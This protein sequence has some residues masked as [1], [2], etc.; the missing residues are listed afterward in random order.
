MNE[1]VTKRVM[2]NVTYDLK[3][4]KN[5]KYLITGNNVPE[6]NPGMSRHYAF[7]FNTYVFLQIFNEINAKKLLPSEN[8]P[9]EGLFNN[10]FFITILLISMGF[11]VAFV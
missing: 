1:T 3:D 5:K 7:L 2:G 8:N 9:F 10:Y 11:Q 4:A 6:I